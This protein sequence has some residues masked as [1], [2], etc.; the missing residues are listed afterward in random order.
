MFWY[1]VL[2]LIWPWACHLTLPSF[3]FL[4]S[5]KGLSIS[6][7]LLG[8]DLARSQRS[9]IIRLLPISPPSPE[10]ALLQFQPHS[11]NKTLPMHC[12]VLLYFFPSFSVCVA[13]KEIYCQF[14]IFKF[15]IFYHED[16]RTKVTICF[17]HFLCWSFALPS[18]FLLNMQ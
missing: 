7:M 15:L 1:W 4:T 12:S 13:F 6:T 3:I 9:H 17:F 2:I 10:L 18:T 16:I 11:Y 5:K 8:K 14:I